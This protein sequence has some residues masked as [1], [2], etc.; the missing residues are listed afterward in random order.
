MFVIV[1]Y[2]IGQKRVGKVMKICRKYLTHMQKSVFE[3]R[4]TEAKLERL[5]RELD[6]VIDVQ[7]DAVCI[8]RMDTL[9]FL[10]K[11]QIGVVKHVSNII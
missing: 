4:I 5:K 1:A 2:D 8:Y 6:K 10:R 3:G 11:E 7:E 9:T